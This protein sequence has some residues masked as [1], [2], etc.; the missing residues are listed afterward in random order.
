MR[1]AGQIGW[2]VYQYDPVNFGSDHN[3][4]LH[5]TSQ[6]I[7]HPPSAE[8]MAETTPRTKG[9]ANKRASVHSRPSDRIQL[10]PTT[11]AAEPIGTPPW[12]I[13]TQRL[14]GEN[15]LLHWQMLRRDPRSPPS[16][17][18]GGLSADRAA[19]VLAFLGGSRLARFMATVEKTTTAIPVPVVEDQDGG[20]TRVSED[21]RPPLEAAVSDPWVALLQ[22]GV[23]LLEQ[24]SAASRAGVPARRSSTAIQYPASPTCA[25]RCHAQ[26]SSTAS[27]P[28]AAS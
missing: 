10:T 15:C 12:R 22:S 24:L 16:D 28:P 3:L 21:Q 25:F 9:E 19:D 26:R 11:V 2:C 1:R 4:I 23:A 8:Y 14:A 17:R 18:H 20:S 5:N 27:L 6:Q 7:A 13:Q